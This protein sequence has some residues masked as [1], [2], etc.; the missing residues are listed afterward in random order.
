ML[1]EAGAPADSMLVML[2]GEMH[3][4]RDNGTVFVLTAP[5][6]SGMLPYSRLKNFPTSMRAVTPSRAAS[7]PVSFFPEMLARFPE[8]G[9]RLVGIM[10]DRIREGTRADLQREKLVSLGKLSAGLA[11]ELNNP[12]AAARRSAES[13]R[14]AV[15]R[16]REVNLRLER[17]PLTAEQLAFLAKF[18]EESFAAGCHHP[19]DTLE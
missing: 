12:A 8:L 1:V 16:L 11:H 10:S 14:E 7:L 4:Q 19:A 15:S 6:I 5:Q 9:Q 18:E 3:G 13:L 17:R 2:E